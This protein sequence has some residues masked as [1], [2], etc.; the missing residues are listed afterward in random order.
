[1]GVLGYH[2]AVAVIV[3]DAL[4]ADRPVSVALGVAL[5]CGASF[6]AWA[7]VRMWVTGAE[8]IVLLEHVWVACAAAS[9][10]LV[11]AGEP[12]WPWLDV[13]SVALAV[14]LACGRAGCLLVGCCH[15]F[16]SGIG[17]V[18]T[19][20]THP[21]RGV[22]LF[23]LP[24]VEIL[25]L[26]A[27]AVAGQCLLGGSRP[28]T[29]CLMLAGGYAILRFATEGLRGD[30]TLRRGPVSSGRM[31]ALVQLCGV[32]VIDEF[33][34]QPGPHAARLLWLGPGLLGAAI[35][36][37]RWRRPRPLSREVTRELRRATTGAPVARQG[38]G[39]GVTVSAEPRHFG[40][41]VAIDVDGAPPEAASR[42]CA[43]A[44]GR[45]PDAVGGDGTAHILLDPAGAGPPV[46]AP[47]RT[48]DA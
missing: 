30:R 1:M 32:V 34:R 14:F 19:R 8:N 5:V 27:L 11:A 38:L 25:G 7:F 35:L 31:M 48:A 3:L 44:F 9:G 39:E 45:D 17:I 24:A 40:T 16:P 33:A 28:G 42:L 26:L 37:W 43:A 6:F 13:V 4:A 36:G 18:Y 12:V 23:P 41:H 15:G 22:R 2:L 47:E 29:V 21:L 20:A 46:L 10:Y